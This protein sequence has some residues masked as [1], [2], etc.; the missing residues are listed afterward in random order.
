MAELDREADLRDYGPLG[1][2]KSPLTGLASFLESH[3]GLIPLA[4]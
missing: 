2:L 4:V 3:L 1:F